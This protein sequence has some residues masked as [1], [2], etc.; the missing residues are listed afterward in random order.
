MNSCGTSLAILALMAYGA[1]ALPALAGEPCGKAPCVQP[2]ADAP[3]QTPSSKFSVIPEAA[4]QPLEGA[5]KLENVPVILDGGRGHRDARAPAGGAPEAR[6]DTQLSLL[7]NSTDPLQE[8]AHSR[9][10]TPDAGKQAAGW[11]RLD[12]GPIPEPG[13][14]A[15]L[16]AG[17]LGICAVARP[18]I[19]TS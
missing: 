18:R 4:A 11:V 14:W 15:V 1:I 12:D 13:A 7:Q 10:D 8:R 6:Q 5:R 16:I 2:G 19:F 3:A 9:S 17:V